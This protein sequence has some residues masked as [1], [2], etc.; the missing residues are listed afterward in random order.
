MSILATTANGSLQLTI[1]FVD[2]PINNHNLSYRS[3]MVRL[4]FL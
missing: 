3:G 1:D 4:S 2:D